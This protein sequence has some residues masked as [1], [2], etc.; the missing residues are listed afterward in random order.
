MS[1][2]E[3]LELI[4]KAAD[5]VDNIYHDLIRFNREN[6]LLSLVRSKTMHEAETVKKLYG[7][8]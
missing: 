6:V 1:D 7:L 5:E 3:R 2:A 8:L 4:N